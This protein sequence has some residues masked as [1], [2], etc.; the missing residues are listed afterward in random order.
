MKN[1]T[2]E[3]IEMTAE[4]AARILD[5]KTSREALDCWAYDP[6]KRLAVC[7][8]ACRVAARVL[9]EHSA[10]LDRSRWEGCEHCT[11]GWDYNDYR[12]WEE[13]ELGEIRI[14]KDELN[15]DVGPYWETVKIKFCPFCGRPLTEEA[16]ADWRKLCGKQLRL[17]LTAACA[18]TFTTW[19]RRNDE[20]V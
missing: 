8:E 19:R 7:N 11:A 6:E 13:G 3:R 15:I 12:K 18:A 2:E 4:E 9:R 10:K 14:S 16:W 5:P 17:I 1:V 20:T